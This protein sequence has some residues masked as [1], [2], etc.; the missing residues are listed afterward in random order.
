MKLTGLHLLLTYQCTLECDHCFVWGSPRQ[1]GTMTLANVREIVRQAKDLQTVKS[2]YFEGGE[3]FLYYATLL[4]GV[5]EAKRARFSVGI[6]SNGYWAT[7]PEDAS[8]WLRP[9]TGLLS[10]LSLSSDL[11]HYDEKLSRQSK[12]ASRAAEKLGISVGIIEV[13]QPQAANADGLGQLPRGESGVMFRGRAAAKLADSARKQSWD[14]FT[15]CTHEDLRDPGRVHI[16]PHG[17]LHV[18]QGI[19]IGNL[20]ERPLA[21]I[22]QTYNAEAHPIAGALLQGGPTEL[23]R[24]YGLEHADGYADGC[25]LCYETRVAL[26]EKFPEILSPDQAYGIF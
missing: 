20:F 19:S 18:C 22:C 2:V 24:R 4:A 3:P 11:Y 23:A 26:R 1:R 10:D 25:H 21:Q 16:D 8:E 14:T 7:S 12:N 5:R 6:V 17:N 13:A 9:F 15:K